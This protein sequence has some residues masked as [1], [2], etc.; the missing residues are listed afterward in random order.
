MVLITPPLL[1]T[2]LYFQQFPLISDY[3]PQRFSSS[4]LTSVV[5]ITHHGYASIEAPFANTTFDL[6]ENEIERFSITKKVDAVEAA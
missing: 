3:A 4:Q 2:S 5:G 6:D 1:A